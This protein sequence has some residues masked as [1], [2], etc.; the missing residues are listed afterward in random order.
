MSK[1]ND[2]KEYTFS[3]NSYIYSYQ[4]NREDLYLQNTKATRDIIESPGGTFK[5]FTEQIHRYWTLHPPGV[6]CELLHLVTYF[7]HFH[8]ASCLIQKP[9]SNYPGFSSRGWGAV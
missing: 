2:I 9:G 8:V 3:Y 1:Y 5:P 7:P 4:L 6:L